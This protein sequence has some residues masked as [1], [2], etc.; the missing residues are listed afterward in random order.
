MPTEACPEALKRLE[1]Q[2]TEKRGSRPVG[3]HWGINSEMHSYCFWV[4]A[5]DIDDGMS[6][7]DIALLLGIEQSQV[8]KIYLSAIEKLKNNINSKE[9]QAFVSAIY[10]KMNSS[11]RANNAIPD[12]QIKIPIT[13]VEEPDPESIKKKKKL[14]IGVGMPLH[15]SGTKVDLYGLYTHKK[16][17]PKRVSRGK[18]KKQ[19]KT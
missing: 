4:L 19:N 16:D 1:W 7:R 18:T 2:E 5:N 12:S 11:S 13:H 3:C 14:R 6:D 8:Q 9:V 10:E 17:Q 15:R